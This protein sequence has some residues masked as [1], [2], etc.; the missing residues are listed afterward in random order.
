MLVNDKDENED[1][2]EEEEEDAYVPNTRKKSDSY[3]E[4]EEKTRDLNYGNSS[5]YNNYSNINNNNNNNNNSRTSNRQ[6][7][8]R[9]STTGQSLMQPTTHTTHDDMDIPAL[10]M[11]VSQHNIIQKNSKIIQAKHRRGKS[12][13]LSISHS[14]ESKSSKS[15]HGGKQSR[16]S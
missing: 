6:Y 16:L 12:D 3:T 2:Q 11:S 13:S 1:D 7:I 9:R 4:T 10:T 8:S 5:N 15:H 14:T